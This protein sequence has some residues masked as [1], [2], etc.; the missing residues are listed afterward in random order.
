LVI[1][2]IVGAVAAFVSLSRPR[3][4]GHILTF[5]C[6][7]VAVVVSYSI[8]LSFSEAWQANFIRRPIASAQPA[9]PRSVYGVAWGVAPVMAGFDFSTVH[10][11]RC[12]Q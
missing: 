2:L 3:T 9:A 12:D 10:S 7:A 5:A 8:H 1:I 11:N 4:G 6:L